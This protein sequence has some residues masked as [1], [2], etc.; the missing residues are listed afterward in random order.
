MAG[1]L[2]TLKRLQA[3]DA[4]LY[5][6]RKRQQQKPLE[7]QQVQAQVAAQDQRCQAAAD[8]LKSLQLAQKDKEGDLETREGQVKKL[9]G[10]LFQLKTNKE[11][12]AMQRE[13]EA[14]KAD[15][16]LL[17]EAI[18]KLFDEIDQAGKERQRQQQALAQEQEQ[19]R[20]TQARVDQELRALGDQ[21]GQL[22]RQREGILPDVPKP[23]LVAY[24]RVLKIR[25]GLALVPIVN[26]TCGGCN[27]RLPPQV[28]N[29][30][31]L[32]ADLV[33]CESCN[34]ILYFDETFSKL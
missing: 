10:Q 2:D 9:Q 25:D 26:D 22:E 29:Q 30:V 32:K 20:Q 33:S 5:D 7:L 28:L 11:Y 18:L 17:E 31:L 27:R 34:R 6:L 4:E 15:A 8:R 1:P 21:I 12:S 13:I 23:A 3:I 24:E 19:L 16:S 14:L